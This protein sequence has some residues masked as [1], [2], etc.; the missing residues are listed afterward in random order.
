MDA[1]DVVIYV[2]VCMKWLMNR[3][4]SQSAIFLLSFS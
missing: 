1:Y 4:G 3:Q 2:L